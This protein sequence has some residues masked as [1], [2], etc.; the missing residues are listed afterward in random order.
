MRT[1]QQSTLRAIG[2]MG[3]ASAA[4]LVIGLVRMKIVAL[5][6][7]AA[8]VGLLGIFQNF[9]TAAAALGGLGLATAAPREIAAQSAANG[10][11][12][13][14]LA[15]RAVVTA[16]VGLGLL[17][18]ILIFVLRNPIASA[19]FGSVSYGSAIAWLGIGVGLSII[20]AG[21]SGLLSGLQRIGDLAQVTLFGAVLGSIVGVAAIWLIPAAG[22]LIY[23]ISAPAAAVVVAALYALRLPRL[24]RSNADGASLVGIWRDLITLGVATMAG[25]FVAAAGPLLV[26]IAIGDR[27]GLHELGLFQASW[28]LAAVYLAIVLQAMS[29]DYFPRLT[30]DIDDPAAATAAVNAQTKIALLLGGPVILAIMGGAPLI[31]H[32]LY[33]SEFQAAAS[34]LRWQMLGDVL[35]LMSWPL[36]FVLLASRRGMVFLA[37][38]LLGT[39]VFVGGTLLLL[40]R[41]GFVAAGVSYALMYAIYLPALFAI[42]RRQ[43]GFSWEGRVLRD[44][45]LLFATA[46][47][48]LLIASY[49]D[50]PGIV[51]GGLSASVFGVRALAHLR[52]AR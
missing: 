43:I 26:R 16:S 9:M 17:S 11:A 40:E 18:A 2:L 13:E 35:K 46:G 3:S 29:A 50:W 45:A 41:F 7:G 10:P 22:I 44:A 36:G 49:G 25:S 15:K 31:L 51:A 14:A 19:V 33:A 28:S 23:V 42:C 5:L 8:G 39:A 30:R 6:V 12:G 34:M 37:V 4:N 52:A 38:E 27:M 48:V 20:Y 21:Q 24:A 47:L 1:S 32:L